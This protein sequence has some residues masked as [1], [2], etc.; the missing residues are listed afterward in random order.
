MRKQSVLVTGAARGIG[1]ACVRLLLLQGAYVTAFDKSPD[2]L[3]S[4]FGD[5]ADVTCFVG[6]V[7][8]PEDCGAAVELAGSKTGR[9]DGVIHCAALHSST[10]WT[11]LQFDELQHVLS[12]N[13]GGTFL[14]AQAA[15][16]YMMTHGG[17]SIVLTSS[18]NVI[19]G[20]IGGAAGMGGP[21]YVA[22]KS[23]I[24]GL[25]RSLARSL[26]PHGINVNG[27]MP[28]VTDTPMIAGY[29]PEH[30]TR[31]ISQSPLGRIAEPS[32]IAKVC[33]FLIS[34]GAAYMAGENVVVNGG[35]NF[36]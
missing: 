17:G 29:T 14:I 10:F 33:C 6:D 13:V 25:V 30:R 15:G 26:G 9:L 18:S 34:E 24:V 35:A 8:N 36:G 11:D 5:N 7:S 20:G 1:E 22:S 12:V 28:G 19:A 27:I 31:Q 21:A 2:I 23:A 32:D 4:A 3:P 16:K